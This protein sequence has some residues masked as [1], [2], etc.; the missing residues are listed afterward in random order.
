MLL[1]LAN[2]FLW[3]Y[4]LC[5]MSFYTMWQIRFKNL[6]SLTVF[7]CC[8]ESVY[9]CTPNAYKFAD[10]KLQALNILLLYLIGL[11]YRRLFFF[12]LFSSELSH[13]TELGWT[14][15][16]KNCSVVPMQHVRIYEKLMESL[17]RSEKSWN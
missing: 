16:K 14:F 8:Q 17:K 15:S 5:T 9:F 12:L 10:N 13:K 11:L 1:V 3:G 4:P 2:D 6:H 7:W